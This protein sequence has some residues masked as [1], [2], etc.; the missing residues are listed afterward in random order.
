MAQRI[1]LFIAMAPKLQDVMPFALLLSSDNASYYPGSP[2][3]PSSKIMWGAAKA[4]QKT[5]TGLMKLMEVTHALPEL[6]KACHSLLKNMSGLVSFRAGEQDSLQERCWILVGMTCAW[7]NAV[8]FNHCVL[9]HWLSQMHIPA[10]TQ[11]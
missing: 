9:L 6:Q 2:G 1:G 8:I 4:I 5:L 7:S 3:Q 11:I 10:F